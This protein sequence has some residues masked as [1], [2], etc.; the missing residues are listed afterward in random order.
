VAFPATTLAGAAVDEPSLPVIDP[1][2]LRAYRRRLRQLDG[3]GSPEATEG[4]HLA[5]AIDAGRSPTGLRRERGTTE[6]ARKAVSKCLREAISRIE[7]AAPDVARHLRHAI[8]TGTCCS[9]EPEHPV[10]WML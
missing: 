4:A 5:K 9:Y 8:R 3:S 2:A 7:P 6:R 10:T 1:D